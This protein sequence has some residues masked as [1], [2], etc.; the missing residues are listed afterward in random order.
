MSI[1]E[2]IFL[3]LFLFLCMHLWGTTAS[4][5][6]NGTTYWQLAL[7]P[8]LVYSLIIG[9]RY[10]GADYLFYKF[11]LEHAFTYYEDQVGFR[12][13]NQGINLIGLSYV[14]GYIFYS[15]IFI[16]CGFILIR[17][18]REES[19]YMY[20]FFVPATLLFIT[21]IIRQGVALSFLFLAI[22]FF[23]RRNWLGLALS[24]LIGTSIHTAFLI[25]VFLLGGSFVLIKKPL[26][27]KITI[28]VYLFC[29]Y[30]FDYTS[31]GIIAPIIQK[32]LSFSNKFQT[33]VD[34]ADFWFSAEAANTKF[35]QGVFASIFSS[36]FY[37]SVI[38]IGYQALKF[39]P[40]NRVL[41][42]YNSFVLGTILFRVVFLFEILRRFAEPLVMLYFIV[43][44]YSIYVFS[45]IIK[46]KMKLLVEGKVNMQTIKRNILLYRIGM[47]FI[48]TYL[49]MFWGRF[50]FLNPQYIF[51]WNK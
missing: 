37:I 6:K 24:I 32:Y 26:S 22:Y 12:W 17:D 36:L 21:G 49:M 35:E 16:I 23:S 18:F 28:P 44:G 11:R 4:R 41:Y 7:F 50:I 29:T 8:I 34:S 38:F 13:L 33:Y 51:F 20:S 43:L 39:K 14:G 48:L 45:L 10:W 19:S 1:I 27:W 47:G 40:S 46:N 3:F 30:L 9:S 15:L 2:H 5:I 25:T 42:L 31:V